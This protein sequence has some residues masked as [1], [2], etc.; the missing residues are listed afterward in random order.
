MIKLGLTQSNSIPQFY[1]T[2]QTNSLVLLVDKI[3][4]DIIFTGTYEAP[5]NFPFRF[6]Q[7]LKLG[8]TAERPV[9]MQFLV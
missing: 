3:V 4:D 2:I 1:Q 9:Y 6:D 5:P 7:R 8:C